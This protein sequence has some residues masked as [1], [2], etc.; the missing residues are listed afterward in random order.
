MGGRCGY[1]WGR[2]EINTKAMT[3]K[4]EGNS[5]LGRCEDDNKADLK[6]TEWEGMD[7]MN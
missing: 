7:F 4:P 1:L 3:W 6:E 5:L 2:R